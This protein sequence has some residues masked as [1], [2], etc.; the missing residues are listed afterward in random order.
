MLGYQ[1]EGSLLPALLTH[2]CCR[3]QGGIPVCWDLEGTIRKDSSRGVMGTGWYIMQV[4]ATFYI[5]SVFFNAFL[6]WH[7]QLLVFAHHLL[8][9]A[10]FLS[11]SLY[12]IYQFFPSIFSL[13]WYEFCC[14]SWLQTS[15]YSCL[16]LM[17]P[18]YDCMCILL[19]PLWSWSRSLCDPPFLKCF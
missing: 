5:C 18:E 1:Q 8:H 4:C 10:Y 13:Q 9:T 11:S 3:L 12:C 7:C 2:P 6:V 19:H 16:L 17:S 15:F 14:L